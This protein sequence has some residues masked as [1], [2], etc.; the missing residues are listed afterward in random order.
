[1]TKTYQKIRK[2][3]VNLTCNG[4]EQHWVH[5]QRSFQSLGL[6]CPSVF[7]NDVHISWENPLWNDCIFDYFI[8]C[9]D[10][11]CFWITDISESWLALCLCVTLS[12]T[13]RLCTS[14]LRH[15]EYLRVH[16]PAT[17]IDVF[18]SSQL[19][20]LPLGH[21][22]LQPHQQLDD[23]DGV[24]HLHRATVTHGPKTHVTW[25]KAVGDM[26]GNESKCVFTMF[27]LIYKCPTKDNSL[28]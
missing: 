12:Y 6:C 13:S 23:R 21:G 4:Q 19:S 24:P 1:M 26:L 25:S 28:T 3:S 11:M 27:K 7:C 15:L 10:F 5:L 16:S 17:H 2:I 20:L 8:P 22:L 18:C 9:V 14:F